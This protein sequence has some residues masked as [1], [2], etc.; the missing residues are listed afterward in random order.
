M[1]W[2]VL[3]CALALSVCLIA[4]GICIQY[5]KRSVAGVALVF[6]GFVVAVH[7]IP[8]IGLPWPI[9]SKEEGGLHVNFLSMPEA[10]AIDI[11]DWGL[12]TLAYCL[13]A[14]RLSVRW[15][16]PLAVVMIVVNLVVVEFVVRELG[17]S[18]YWNIWH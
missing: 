1:E 5:R 3:I 18:F 10:W 8:L 6:L 12:A 16:A 14:K 7:L 4:A 11:V 9:L 13:L 2:A 17:L 15:V